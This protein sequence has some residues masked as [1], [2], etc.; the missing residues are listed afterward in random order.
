MYPKR[1]YMISI[2]PTADNIH[3]YHLLKL[4]SAS[5]LYDSYHFPFVIKYSVKTYFETMPIIWYSPIFNLFIYISMHSWIPTIFSRSQPITIITFISTTD[6][7][8]MFLIIAFI[9]HMFF[10]VLHSYLFLLLMLCFWDHIHYWV[11]Q[12]HFT[13]F[14]RKA[15][16]F[17]IV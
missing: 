3:F 7:L 5:F 11:L 6:C 10:S 13:I 12:N 1:W 8:F 16:L 17:A 14:S 9:V 2:C 15:F 4:V